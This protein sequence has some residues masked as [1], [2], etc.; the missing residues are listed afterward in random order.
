MTLHRAASDPVM[1]GLPHHAQSHDRTP[2][3]RVREEVRIYK[4]ALWVYVTVLPMAAL[5]FYSANLTDSVVLMVYLVWYAVSFAAQT[6]TLYA[7][8]QSIRQNPYAYPYGT[9]KLE[10][11]SSF[12]ESLLILLPGLYL[13]TDA[14]ATPCW[15]NSSMDRY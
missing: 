10:N 12:L 11:F 9:G 4:L 2:D 6:F 15:R 5:F 1:A 7:L 13:I 3:G 14:A 8:R